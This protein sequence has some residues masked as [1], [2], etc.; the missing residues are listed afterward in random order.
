[1]TKD[2]YLEMC[3]GLGTEP[4][5]EEIPPEFGDLSI[6]TQDSLQIFNYLPDKWSDMSGYTGKDLSNLFTIFK[7][8]DID[9]SNWLLYMD[10][11]NVIID[12]RIS[13]T[14]NKIQKEAKSEANKRG[15]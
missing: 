6:Q 10:L 11:L 2:M 7:L 14:N 15:K 4:K 12:E 13:S 9:K 8:F 5:E 3:E 1:M